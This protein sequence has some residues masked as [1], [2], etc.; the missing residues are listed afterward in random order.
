MSKNFKIIVG[1]I[2]AF[3]IAILL[4]FPYPIDIIDV[5]T[6]E[7][8]A[9]FSIHISAWRIVFEPFFGLMLF[10]N[11]G[12]YAIGEMFVLVQWV[13]A[14]FLIYSAI[15]YF[16]IKDRKISKRFLTGQIVNIPFVIAVWFTFFVI[17]LFLSPYFPSNTIVN[18]SLNAVLVTTHAHSQFSHDGL[19]SQKNIWKWHKYN[20][21]DAFFITDHNTHDKTLDFVNAQR[22][23]KFPAEPLIMGGEEF[24]GSNHLSLLGLKRKFSTKGLSDSAVIA[25]TRAD[26]GAVLVNHWFDGERKTLEFFRDLGVDGYEIANS[27]A[28]VYYNRAIYEKIKSF[29]ETNNL[30]MVVGLDFHGY[31]NVCTMW[32][33]MEIPGWHTMSA[34][35]KEAAIINVIKSREQSK[36]RGLMYHDRPYYENTNLFWIIPAHFLNYFRTL[37]VYQVISWIVWILLI[38]FVVLKVKSDENLKNILGAKNILLIF[39]FV[40]GLFMLAMGISYYLEIA[41]VA[42]SDNDIYIEYSNLFFYVAAAYLA[43]S[44]IVGYFRFVR[45]K[46]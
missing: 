38:A 4:L 46:K 44:S 1:V 26:G 21:F 10:L 16:K 20:N 11:R 41:K 39:G 12:L 28:E 18:N 22:E 32:N 29:C 23:G 27:A 25:L 5:L 31:G 30:I 14:I 15:K 7:P 35:D 45:N 43:Y 37:N 17:T 3:V 24:S 33:A 6:S 8:Q 13:L 36:L 42:G 2:V 34:D 40:G 19:I 9:D